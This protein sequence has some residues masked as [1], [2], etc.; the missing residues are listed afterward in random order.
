MPD[1][2]NGAQSTSEELV[3]AGKTGANAVSKGRRI[4]AASEKAAAGNIAGAAVEILKDEDFRHFLICAISVLLLITVMVMYIFPMAIYEGIQSVVAEAKEAYW[5]VYYSGEGGNVIKAAWSFTTTLFSGLWNSLTN[6]LTAY[7]DGGSQFY[8]DIDGE[9]IGTA[10]APGDS[11]YIKLQATKEKYRI[12]RET[13]KEAIETQGHNAVYN[14]AYADFCSQYEPDRDIFNGFI[15][16]E[17]GC[18]KEFSDLLGLKLIELYDIVNDNDFEQTRLS[19][20]L[21]WLGY[22]N[23]SP[24]VNNIQIFDTVVPVKGWQGTYMPQYLVDE[25]KQIA[26]KKGEEAKNQTAKSRKNGSEQNKAYHE[27]YTDA[28]SGYTDTHGASAMDMMI[29]AYVSPAMTSTYQTAYRKLNE[30]SGRFEME[31]YLSNTELQEGIEKYSDEEEGYVNTSTYESTNYRYTYHSKGSYNEYYYDNAKQV[32][33]TQQY[34]Q[35]MPLY[36]STAGYTYLPFTTEYISILVY[37][38]YEIVTYTA[39]ITVIPRTTDAIMNT[40]G[41]LKGSRFDEYTEY[42]NGGQY[43]DDE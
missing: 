37:Q 29:K 34:G 33:Y 14:K 31:D 32:Y 22:D 12:R 41:I 40:A 35:R 18:T 11:V 30:Y 7:T 17:S 26:E 19:D 15:W 20:Y 5:S 8:T 9:I 43:R 39:Y 2:K 27:A 28:Y 38:R 42:L 1:E 25:A 36:W 13:I 16:D 6:A 10:D 24:N 3:N 4:A 21:Q 23:G